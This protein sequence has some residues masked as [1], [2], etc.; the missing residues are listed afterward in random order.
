MRLFQQM[1]R[2]TKIWLATGV[3]DTARA[4]I[5]LLAF[6]LCAAPFAAQAQPTPI[7]L[8]MSNH[9]TGTIALSVRALQAGMQLALDDWN[10]KGGVLGRKIELLVRDDQTKPALAID[11]VRDLF[12]REKVDALL[13]PATSG[14]ALAVS[15]IAEQYKKIDMITVSTSPRLTM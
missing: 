7:K 9:Y 13:G 4:L 15:Q 10:A 2:A 11:H 3:R 5:C 12:T 1:N 8:G 6:V 14:I